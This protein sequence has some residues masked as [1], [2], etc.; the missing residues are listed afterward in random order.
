[1]IG[2]VLGA[3]LAVTGGVIAGYHWLGD[4]PDAAAG[5]TVAREICYEQEVTTSAEP[6]DEKRIAGTVIGALVGGAVGRDVG[7]RDVTTAAGAAAGAL[8]GNQVQ[9][10]F[11]ENRAETTIETRCEPVQ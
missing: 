3:G 4:E 8:A 7:D 5:A 2:A 10:K 1:V 9:K 11:Q 6:K